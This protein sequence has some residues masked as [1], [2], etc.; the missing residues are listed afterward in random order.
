[1]KT[2]DYLKN[3]SLLVLSTSVLLSTNPAALAEQ[4]KLNN[5]VQ[6]YKEAKA[7]KNREKS[8]K[9][10]SKGMYHIYKKHEGMLNITK[11][12]SMPGAWMNPADNISND[13]IVKSTGKTTSAVKKDMLKGDSLQIS[14]QIDGYINSEDAKA[15][16]NPVVLY[17]A[18]QYY[19][20]AK[21]SNGM[22][23]ISKEK[24][25]AGAWVNPQKLE[26][27]N[28]L[29]GKKN[30]NIQ[31][32]NN[33]YLNEAINGYINSGDARAKRNEVVKLA[34]GQYFI[35]LEYKG[36]INITKDK[37]SAGAWINP[38]DL[39][40]DIQNN[41]SENTKEEKVVDMKQRAAQA[42]YSL[43]NEVAGYMN[44]D[45]AKNGTNPVRQVEKGKY[46]IY[47]SYQG[48]LNISK[49]K[50]SEGI[51]INPY[52]NK[53]ILENIAEEKVEY[54][55]KDEVVEA[56]IEK[57]ISAVEVKE[58]GFD[59]E[60]I[61]K[62][63]LAKLD[64]ESNNQTVKIEVAKSIKESEQ[65]SI[66]EAELEREKE[67][68]ES[69]NET[70]AEE[71]KEETLAETYEETKLETT[72]ESVAE[73]SGETVEETIAETSVETVEDTLVETSIETEA[74]SVQETIEEAKEETFQLEADSDAYISLADAKEAKNTFTKLEKGVYYINER[75]ES[76]LNI[77]KQRGQAGLWINPNEKQ[78]IRTSLEQNK[79]AE[80][81]VLQNE[82]DG[83]SRAAD[84]LSKSNPYTKLA[85]GK[86][87]VYKKLA[88]AINVSKNADIPGAWIRL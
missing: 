39:K 82:V 31:K 14:S 59:T 68:A 20:F 6:V 19:V 63:A 38:S 86:Y 32:T 3:G 37:K 57:K 58:Q 4:Y 29:A 61:K 78:E 55:S 36:M 48:M 33:I 12:K 77:S 64:A 25:S 21:A 74:E 1:M 80:E 40:I 23:N 24:N 79:E 41:K 34:K 2:R 54:K 56:Y 13:S 10:Y 84:A 66:E 7:A 47:S 43:R 42:I 87:K 52:D 75:S 71:S 53:I 18:G 60:E 72:E 11:T 62:E 9:T 46:Y 81:I 49:E 17:K 28:D 73:T 45:D 69:A 85:P 30:S 88:G 83:Y 65:E 44:S 22:I 5:S 76:M 67:L 15:G 35:Y 26:N 8:Y 51:W 27:I 70:L 50:Q 16:K